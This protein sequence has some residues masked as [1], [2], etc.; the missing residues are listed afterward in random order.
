MNLDF[1][2]LLAEFNAAGVRYLV[3]GA[4]A[5]AAHGHVSATRDLDVW[6]CPSPENARR[7]MRALEAFG[8]PLQDLTQ[9]DLTGPDLV[10]QIGV[11]PVRIDVLTSIYGVEFEDA[12]SDRLATKFGGVD[13]CVLSRRCLIENK[14]SA[15]RPR[16]RADLDWLERDQKNESQRRR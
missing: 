15:D 4:H 7:V 12:W 16:D 9:D 5:L 3:V 1:R 14:R 10:F 2:D 8:A 11:D 6:V 13:V